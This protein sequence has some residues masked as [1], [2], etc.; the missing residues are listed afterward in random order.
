MGLDIIIKN[1]IV[2]RNIQT[3]TLGARILLLHAKIYCPEGK[4]TM[5]W[6]YVQKSFV[7]KL[8]VLKVYDDGIITMDNFEDTTTDI[9]LKITTYRSFHSVSWIQW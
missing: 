1:S 2:E 5:L 9:T 3:L 4:T 6:T 7:E 8:N